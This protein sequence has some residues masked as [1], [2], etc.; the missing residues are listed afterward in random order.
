MHARSLAARR[1]FGNKLLPGSMRL[2]VTGIESDAD[3][4]KYDCRESF[5]AIENA[6]EIVRIT[7]AKRR[8]I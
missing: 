7:P 4:D 5:S 2:R 6:S 3:D 1:S 8:Q